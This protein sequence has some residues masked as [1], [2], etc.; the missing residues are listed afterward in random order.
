M[1]TKPNNNNSSKKNQPK[2]P[3]SSGKKTE[4]T[5]S[6]DLLDIL[7]NF[8]AGR[9]KTIL[10]M[11]LA[12]TL[13]FS[14]LLFDVKVG[15]GGDDSAYVLRAYDFVHS[16]V[17]PGY[18]GALYPL[19]LSPFIW[20]FGI[21]LPL[22]K[23]LSLLFM[24]VSMF[25]F[26]KAFSKRLPQTI[27]ALAFV[28][29]SFNYYMLY[30]ASQTYSE[31]LFLMLQAIFF[32]YMAT[33]FTNDTPVDQ[34][35]KKYFIL[36]LILFL[37]SLTKN[38]AYAAVAATI[39]YFMLGKQW[40]SILLTLGGFLS[41]LVPFEILKHLL[42]STKG[43]QFSSQGNSLMYKDFYNQT[44]GKED[45]AG[46]IQR[47]FDNSNL[48]FSK[49][50]FKF[51]GLTDF[52]STEI[53]PIL[54]VL[55]WAFL[56]VA[57]FWAIR[58]NKVLLLTAI[59]T[60]TLCAATF[61]AIQKQWDQWRII[62]IYFP[63]ILILVFS[64]LYYVSKTPKVKFLQIAIPVLALLFFFSSFPLTI[65]N[66][67]KQKDILSHNLQ[68]D[69]LYGLT[70]DWENYILMSKWIAKNTPAESMTAVRKAD[71]SFIYGER[72]F[73]GITKVP[74]ISLDSL[75]KLMPD[76]S[77]YIGFKMQRLY[78][79]ALFTDPAFRARTLAFINGKFA[80]GDEEVVDGN[81][82][83]VYRFSRAEFTLLEPKL[84]ELGLIY[85]PDMKG[86]INQLQTITTE[87]AIYLPDM[88]LD[89][90][91]KNNVRYM[92]LASLRM[93]PAENTGNIINTVQRYMFFIQAKYPNIF[94]EINSIGTDEGAQ[95]VEIM[96]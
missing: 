7:D 10:Y 71:I 19:V 77:L 80:F 37:L 68:G 67:K 22:L 58:K 73:Y 87:Y 94:K 34:P 63:L 9:E 30:F 31:A 95:V 89:L 49:H 16:F 56:G 91:R 84:K 79:T 20:L 48:Y 75:L 28:L 96:Y 51:F 69:M 26:Y 44:K 65:E 1:S 76:T 12:L 72:K 4:T 70:M 18:Q 86:W 57:L 64:A 74:G 40:K 53:N 25:F 83:G 82:L 23:L 35:L 39:G 27:V 8:F 14:L 45:F 32:W 2:Q 36:G 92:M 47:F 60:M 11:G 62:I 66:S 78:E 46:F 41:F 90:L 61:F 43:L 85:N 21:K 38:V 52:N 13:L 24:M 17:Y 5:G 42:W 59:Y 15:P 55:V 54:T 29:L 81:A 3:V 6:K 50:L 93:N 33:N 88:L